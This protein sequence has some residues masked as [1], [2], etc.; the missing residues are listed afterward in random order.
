MMR[1][2]LILVGLALAAIGIWSLNGYM[3]DQAWMT[4]DHHQG[5]GWT[6]AA[7][8][9]GLLIQAWPV[10]LVGLL[11]GLAIGHGKGVWSGSQASR[12]DLAEREQKLTSEHERNEAWIQRGDQRLAER[13][14]SLAGQ[15]DAARSAQASAQASIV[16]AERR[17]AIAEAHAVDAERRRTNAAAVA[18]RRRRKLARQASNK[19]SP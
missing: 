8:G 7:A 19:S 10:L 11:S 4:Y 17:I 15:L 16:D 1:W 18:E 14:A 3:G 9:W 12:L 5:N 13:E 6:M 2:T